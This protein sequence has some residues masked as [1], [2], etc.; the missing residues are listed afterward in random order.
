MID[1]LDMLNTNSISLEA[2]YDLIDQTVENIH[3]GRADPDWASALGLSKYEARAYAH[4][5]GLEDLVQFRYQGW[6]V[7]CA[8]CHLG[9]DFERDYWWF[10]RAKSEQPCLVHTHCLEGWNKHLQ[11]S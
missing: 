11:I 7:K 10:R 5:A 6:P 9:I 2:A 3:L 8:Y 1:L 4:G